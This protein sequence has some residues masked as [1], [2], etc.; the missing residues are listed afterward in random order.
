MYLRHFGLIQEPFSIAPD[1]R[2][3]FMSERHR[4][5]LAHLRFGMQSGGGFVVLSGEIGA[6]KTTVCRC[7]LEQIPQAC[8][9]AYLFNPKLTAREL[10]QS[11]CADF[12]IAPQDDAAHPSSTKRHV[13]ALNAFLLK[14]HAAGQHNVL[15]ID[16]AQRL[17][18]ALLEQLRLLTNLETNERKLL[19]IVLIGQ[20]E[21]RQMLARPELEQL[22]QRVVARF[23]LGT[24]GAA[25]TEQYVRHR[26]T[27]AGLAGEVP[28]TATALRLIHRLSRGV[29]R[30]INLLCDRALLGAYAQG[31]SQIDRSTVL[32]AAREVFGDQ[33][34]G[35][36]LSAQQWLWLKVSAGFV[37][38]AALVGLLT[39]FATR[40]RSAVRAPAAATA[41]AM[42]SASASPATTAATG[43]GALPGSSTA[44]MAAAAAGSAPDASTIAP[45]SVQAGKPA[46]VS[47]TQLGELLNQAPTD[48]A[49]AWRALAQA[50]GQA[51]LPPG[52]ACAALRVGGLQCQKRRGSLSLLRSLD[53]PAVL[54]LYGDASE[55]RYVILEGLSAGSASLRIGTQPATVS[56]DDLAG[57]WREE[58][59]VLWR[60]PAQAQVSAAGLPLSVEPAW[61]SSQLAHARQG[62]AVGQPATPDTRPLKAQIQAFQRANG[63]SADGQV[64]AA[65][66]M[67]LGRAGASGVAPGQPEP[68]LRD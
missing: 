47:A 25:E 43:S 54:P 23:H 19:Q 44:R 64:G 45:P 30:R 14:A 27:V 34:R 40:D 68:R 56:L 3:L 65:T 32:Q 46:T 17:S 10:L 9:I 67:L 6:G 5:A 55:A 18:L 38:A 51:S 37:F 59:G 4:E 58:F 21:L 12:G 36:A 61:L 66:L 22:T 11:V 8:N 1:P 63:L 7:I 49:T 2:F 52:D 62:G 31:R 39:W 24:L 35:G 15:I 28:F 57:R 60:V 33:R 48:E 20:P 42:S 41:P 53:R 29:P 16:E 13:D 50:W 26:L